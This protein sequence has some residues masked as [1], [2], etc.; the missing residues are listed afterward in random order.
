MRKIILA[1]LV[2]GLF[3]AACKPTDPQIPTKEE[4]GFSGITKQQCTEANGYWNE[5]GSPCAGTDAESGRRQDH[6]GAEPGTGR[7]AG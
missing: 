3:I 4:A 7:S 1:L 5:C 2:L 6:P